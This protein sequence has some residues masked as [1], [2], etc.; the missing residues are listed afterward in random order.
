MLILRFTG[1]GGVAGAVVKLA[2]R[3]WCSHVEFEL[4]PH[5][6]AECG[7]AVL[8][9]TPSHGVCI[10]PAQHG[11]FRVERFA[12]DAPAKVL[13]LARSQLGKPYDWLG[14]VG[15]GMFQDWQE[16]QAWF[17]SELVAWAFCRAGYPL[18]R[19]RQAWRLTPRDLLLSPYLQKLSD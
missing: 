5:P 15:W 12:V 10:R 1:A 13:R 17:C 4:D 7:V 2:T 16:Q 6:R 18:L 3:S 19:T 8:G 14:V 11:A 9:A